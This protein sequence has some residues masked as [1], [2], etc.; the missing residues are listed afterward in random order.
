[1]VREIGKVIRIECDEMD[2]YH[3]CKLMKGDNNS[4]IVNAKRFSFSGAASVSNASY[5]SDL[6]VSFPGECKYA[7]GAGGDTL[8]CER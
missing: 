3:R 4:E 2:G 5:S 6:T 7:L 1:M 8:S